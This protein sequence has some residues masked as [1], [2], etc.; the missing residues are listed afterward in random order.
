MASGR[1][2]Y[3]YGM[4]PGQ[5]GFSENQTPWYLY[6]GTIVA[7]D[8]EA[9]IIT[10]TVPANKILYLTG[11]FLS[12][13]YTGDVLMQLSIDGDLVMRVIFSDI[14]ILP[15]LPGAGFYLTAG[16]V[17]KVNTNNP[18]GCGKYIACTLFGFLEEVTQ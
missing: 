3:W 7:E 15:V 10:Y 4:L 6:D 12:S 11:G 14:F 5:S 8:K 9:D 16:Q 13:D 2:D 18:D 17:I 1:P